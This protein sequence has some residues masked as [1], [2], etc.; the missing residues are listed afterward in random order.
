[1]HR[2]FSF[3]RSANRILIHYSIEDISA[4]NYINLSGDAAAQSKQKFIAES[5]L[6]RF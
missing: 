5:T 2:L 1:M 4:E 6:G 3:K